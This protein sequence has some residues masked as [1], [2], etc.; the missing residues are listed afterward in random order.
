MIII[1]IIIIIITIIKKKKRP[2]FNFGL[3]LQTQALNH[4]WPNAFDL[5]SN[6]TPNPILLYIF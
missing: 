4:Y 2:S 1:I 3:N 5:S 6:V